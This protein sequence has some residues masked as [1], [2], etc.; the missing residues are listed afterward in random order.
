MQVTDNAENEPSQAS[1]MAIDEDG[2][3]LRITLQDAPNDGKIGILGP[4]P[5]VKPPSGQGCLLSA[6]GHLA[7]ARISTEKGSGR[8]LSAGEKR[9]ADAYPRGCSRWL[10]GILEGLP[11]VPME[12]DFSDPTGLS[13]ESRAYI[14]RTP[15]ARRKTMGQFFTPADLRRELLAGISLPAGP[16]ILDPACGTGEFLRSA[17]ELWPDAELHG[18]EI[19]EELAGLS[20]QAVPSAEVQQLDALGVTWEPGYDAVIGNP[21]YFEFRATPEVRKRYASAIS[22]R[23]NSFALFVKL[24]LEM[25]RPGGVLAFV[26]PPSM[27]N[28]RYF[29]ALR[30]EIVESCRIESLRILPAENLFEGAQQ[31]VMLLR[32]VKGEPDDGRHL[33]RRGPFTLFM[34]QPERLTELFRDATTLHQLGYTVRTGSVVWNQVRSALTDQPEGASRLIWAHN[35]RAGELCLDGKPGK[36]SHVRGREALVGPAIVV[37]RVTG[38]GHKA[39]LRAAAIPAG[40]E[41][42]GENHVNVVLP[43]PGTRPDEVDQVARELCGER[44]GAAVRRITG[45]TQ[46]SSVELLH[47][48]PLRVDRVR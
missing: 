3:R 2:V 6:S 36:P 29:R 46:I 24:G 17:R 14:A 42:L 21:P 9:C 33:F 22:G 23:P 48:V 34:E 20:R 25:L 32:L 15:L 8:F 27:N 26:L 45:N 13:A 10:L 1:V 43:P 19:D 39:R 38:L 40:M 30:E 44:A 5:V 28:G 16:R 47:L 31:T 18:F 41:F 37:N 7:S 11:I 12:K 35:I 4:F